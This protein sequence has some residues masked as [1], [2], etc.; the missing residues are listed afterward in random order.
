[1][2]KKVREDI[3]IIPVENADE[4]IKIALTKQPKPIEWT[5]VEK[6]SGTKKDDKSQAS[7]Q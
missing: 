5:E 3:K 6:L 7:I 1:M 2:P 4:V